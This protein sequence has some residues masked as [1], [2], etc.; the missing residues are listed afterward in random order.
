MFS[1]NLTI[2][3]AAAANKTFN[4]V[5]QDGQETRRIDSLTDL[6]N[7]RMMIIRHQT[8]SRN[9]IATNRHNVLFTKKLESAEGDTLLPSVSVAI[10]VPEDVAVTQGIIDD[11]IAFAKNFLT[12]GNT[13]SLLRGES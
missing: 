2:A 3:D 5:Y 9:G 12:V 13:T 7:Q 1:Q 11:L 8:S 10:S 4:L 6:T